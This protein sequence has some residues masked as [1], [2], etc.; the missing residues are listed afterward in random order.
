LAPNPSQAP[1]GRESGRTG[2]F[3]SAEPLSGGPR[4]SR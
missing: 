4:L 2:A 1:R 3:T